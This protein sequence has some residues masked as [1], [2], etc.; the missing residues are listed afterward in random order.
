M[1]LAR[2][3]R[4]LRMVKVCRFLM[5]MDDLKVA[6]GV[7]DSEMEGCYFVPDVWV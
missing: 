7:P 2:R 3:Y 6:E 5:A 4:R 1:L